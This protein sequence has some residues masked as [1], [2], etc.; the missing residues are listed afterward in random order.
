[1]ARRNR[2][3]LPEH[4]SWNYDRH[5]KCRV[6]F[7]KNGFSTYLTGAPWSDDFMRQYAAALDGLK[8]KAAEIGA[9]R[10]LPGSISALVVSYY[11][12]VFPRLKASTQAER[13]YLIERFRAEHGTKP[14][15]LLKREHIAAMIAARSKTPYAANCLRFQLSHPSTSK[16]ALPN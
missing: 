4:C 14:V 2:S 15:R 11:K 6:R 3:G 1:M 7:R 12:L 13:R 9:D 8:A 5:G 16:N 10:M